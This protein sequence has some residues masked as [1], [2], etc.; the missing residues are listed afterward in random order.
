MI[1]SQF[2]R[3]AGGILSDNAGRRFE[4]GKTSGTIDRRRL[5]YATTGDARL[6]KRAASRKF[7]RYAVGLLIDTSGSM[8][9]GEG[10]KLWHATNIAHALAHALTASGA[11]MLAWAF[12]CRFTPIDPKT[13]LD[14]EGLHKRITAH[15][16]EGRCCN[17]DGDALLKASR[18][19]AR[20]AKAS[21]SVPLLI[22]LSDGLPE[23][24]HA[25]GGGEAR[26]QAAAF[27]KWASDTGRAASKALYFEFTQYAAKQAE[28]LMPVYGVGI[29]TSAP[30][31]FYREHIAI[32]DPTAIYPALLA[33]LGKHIR[34]G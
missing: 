30:S 19:L 10:S 17:Q 31:N 12:N 14:P 15:Y 1:Q 5:A 21:G 18:D 27:H 13:L 25:L 3:R 20:H 23:I 29:Q 16:L 7:K 9:M 28:R 2:I 8:G 22:V 34:R 11:S 33:W 6:F 4:P 26:R 24:F 32:H